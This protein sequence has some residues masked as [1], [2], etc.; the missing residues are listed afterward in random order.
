MT[1]STQGRTLFE[2]VLAELRRADRVA[3]LLH[4]LEGWD[5]RLVCDMYGLDDGD[6]QQVIEETGTP[7]GWFPLIAGYDSIPEPP[8]GVVVPEGFRSYFERLERREPA[9]ADLVRLKERLGRLYEAG[10]DGMRREAAGEDEGPS[11]DEGEEEALGAH[12]PVPAE[13]F[14]EALA[15]ELQIHPISVFHLLEELRAQ[16]VYSAPEVRRLMEDWVS[17]AL[18]LMLGYRWPEQDRYEAHS[19]PAMDPD[20]I[21]A[22]GIIPLV[23]CDDQPTA[24][25]RLRTL[26]ERRFGQ[27]GAARSLEEFRVWVGRD[28]GEWLRRDFFPRHVKQF[29]YRPIAWHLTSPEGTFQALVLYHRLSRET[30]QR[31]RDIYAGAL[32]VRLRGELEGAQGQAAQD[33]RFRIEDVEEFRERIRAIEEGRELR[34]R[35]RCRWKGELETGRPGPYAPDIDDGVKVNI[36]PFQETG[37]LAAEVIKKW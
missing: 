18:L 5:E 36:R 32:V 28:L 31:L 16:G 34:H 26:L 7:A 14:L 30:L 15:Q 25:Q 17:V 8:D 23:P 37:L 6:V 24:E 21:D 13:T 35:I 29:K 10:P 22:D 33:I 1:P 20:L 11:Q 2:A 12:I 3:A 4:A 27:E 19:G 9:A